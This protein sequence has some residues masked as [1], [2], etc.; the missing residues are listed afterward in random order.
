MTF[1]ITT[2]VF[3]GSISPVAIVLRQVNSTRFFDSKVRTLS[4]KVADDI[5]AISR[6]VSFTVLH[7]V[8][9]GLL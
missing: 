9:Q 6:E 1:L 8:E 5:L 7:K 4:V 2:Q 3:V